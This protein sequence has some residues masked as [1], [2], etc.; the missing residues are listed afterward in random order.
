M[1][2]R[3]L[4]ITLGDPAGI[5][6]EV[7]LRA[8][9]MW[10]RE[11]PASDP[12]AHVVVFGT[13]ETVE[14][15]TALLS[16]ADRESLAA[17]GFMLNELT[18][19]PAVPFGKPGPASGKIALESLH[20]ALS[21]LRRHPHAALITAPVAKG[22]LKAAGSRFLDHTTLLGAV[23]GR[24]PIMAFVAGA[25]RVALATVHVP[26]MSVGDRLEIEPLARLIHRA[27]TQLA[28]R[29]KLQAPVRVAVC[30]LNPHAGEGGL[31][32]DEDDEIVRPAIEL[33][34]S[35]NVKPVPVPSDVEVA[36]VIDGSL[37]LLPRIGD[38]EPPAVPAVA[39]EISGP[40][41]ADTVFHR[42]QQGD[43]D[44]VIAMY[45]DQGLI[46]VKTLAFHDAVNVTLNLPF[47]RTSP[48]HG[49][50][51]DIAGRGSADPRSMLAAI[52]LAD[53]WLSVEP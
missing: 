33:A 37:P 3:Q 19:R 12:G 5:G 20:N 25:L 11:R 23:A 32:G 49:T 24:E 1:S 6:P 30:G 9:A 50:A 51:F 53:H 21:H 39:L 38:G 41:P 36:M 44:I 8:L 14:A 17:T 29:E 13:N 10:Q 18:P 42:V 27:A 28:A 43:F 2:E 7:A 15:A 46:P 45:H 31:M 35:G 22:A 16:A 48:D 52:R 26:L 47:I 40:L 34:Q 4:F